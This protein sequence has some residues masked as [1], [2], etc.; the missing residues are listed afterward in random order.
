MSRPPK[1]TK[2][3]LAIITYKGLMAVLLLLTSIGLLLT[4]KDR[5]VLLNFARQS[6][7]TGNR[8]WIR[9]ILTKL[10]VLS[11]KTVEFTGV[12]V[13]IYAIVTTI[14]AVGLWYQQEW[15]EILVLILVGIGIFPELYEIT[16][17]ISIVK[18]I[19]LLIN[20]AVL[21]Y[22]I[23]KLIKDRKYGRSSRR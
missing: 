19:I 18:I 21:V 8:E 7:L 13:L 10:T 22:L 15:A 1:R 17:G 23:S 14:E 2:I 12:A 3:L 11:P 16:T 9:F 20:L 6:S 4:F 5:D